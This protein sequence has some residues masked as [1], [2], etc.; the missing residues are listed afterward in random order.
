MSNNV[1]RDVRKKWARPTLQRMDA[2]SAENNNTGVR[3][4]S[5]PGGKKLS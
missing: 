2:G 4:D 3:T 1:Q 5:N